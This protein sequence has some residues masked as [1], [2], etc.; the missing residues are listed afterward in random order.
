MKAWATSATDVALRE[1][2]AALFVRPLARS[3][4]RFAG[5]FVLAEGLRAEDF[6][7]CYEAHQRITAPVR[8]IWGTDDPWFELAAAKRM[9]GQFAGPATLVEVPGGKLFVHEEFPD[10][11]A[12]EVIAHFRD[13]F[14]G[15]G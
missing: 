14:D 13:A 8:L 1:E 11:F 4:R 3:R 6:D 7:V 2:L 12:G 15:G 10:V 9:L 5:A